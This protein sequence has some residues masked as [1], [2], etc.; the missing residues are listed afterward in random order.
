MGQTASNAADADGPYSFFLSLDLEAVR[1]V[2]DRLCPQSSARVSWKQFFEVFLAIQSELA[3]SREKFARNQW[4]PVCTNYAMSKQ[5][6]GESD[7]ESERER[8]SPRA[9]SASPSVADWHTD[10]ERSVDG[11]EESDAVPAEAEH[12]HAAAVSA[13]PHRQRSEHPVFFGYSTESAREQRERRDL[14]TRL[15]RDREEKSMERAIAARASTL[16]QMEAQFQQQSQTRAKRIEQL[17][18]DYER[19][20]ERK[21]IEFEKQMADV[22]P[23]IAATLKVRNVIRSM[24]LV[25]IEILFICMYAL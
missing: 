14:S 15:Q 23:N 22:K 5:R 8:E 4:S 1:S 10:D 19:E 12:A 24:N 9:E 2:V 3:E 20:Q 7:K 18:Q 11:E 16:D 13:P 6:G 25:L 21:R 17:K